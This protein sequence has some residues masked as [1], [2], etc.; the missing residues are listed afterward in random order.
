M[1]LDL[2]HYADLLGQIKQRIHQGQARAVLSANTEMITT[3]WDVGNIIND[4]QKL[5]GWGAG[6]IP[7]LSR[8]IRNELPK[9]KG[10]SERNI[11]LM[12][13]F[14]REYPAFFQIGQQPVAQLPEPISPVA[15]Q[16]KSE[17]MQQLVAQ[18]LWSH[19]VLLMQKV[20]N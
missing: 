14:Y 20:T 8:D 18:L 16:S 4:R 6:V 5:E 19:N 17:L 7:R 2:V 12:V 9:V 15:E 1:S 11:K 10:F 13:Q 3:Y